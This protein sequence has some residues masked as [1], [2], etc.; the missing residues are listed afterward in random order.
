MKRVCPATS[1]LATRRSLSLHHLPAFP[2]LAPTQKPT[3]RTTIGELSA[4][5]AWTA[6]DLDLLANG[7]NDPA[8]AKE[9]M[10]TVRRGMYP[11]EQASL[12]ARRD[13]ARLLAELTGET[14]IDDET[15]IQLMLE[16]LQTMA[17]T[18]KRMVANQ[19]RIIANQETIIREV[20]AVGSGTAPLRQR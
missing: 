6:S 13:V 8:V 9:A 15:P 2:K 14:T 16:L 4:S 10:R 18:Q 19:E 7:T 11:H 3:R 1:P 17:E 12:E 5:R 20:R